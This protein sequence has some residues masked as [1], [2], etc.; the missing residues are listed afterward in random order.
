MLEQ[1]SQDYASKVMSMNRKDRRKYQKVNRVPIKLYGSTTPYV[2]ADKE[3][4]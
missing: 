1:S 4:T 3:T 2:K